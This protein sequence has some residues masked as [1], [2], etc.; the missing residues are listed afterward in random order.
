MR[1][2]YPGRGTGATD[3]RAASPRTRSVPPPRP[4]PPRPPA[5]LTEG[6]TPADLA[7]ADIYPT[8]VWERGEPLDEVTAH[9]E[10]LVPYFRAAA[11]DGD[12]VLLWIS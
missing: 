11:R 12:G 4:S 1:R 9:Y 8:V 10:A 5:R 6:V 2:R 7:A 3:R